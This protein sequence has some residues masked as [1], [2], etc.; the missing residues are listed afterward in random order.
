MAAIDQSFTTFDPPGSLVTN[1]TSI[2][3]AGVV[4]GWYQ[5]AS[6]THGFLLAKGAITT[7]DVTGSISG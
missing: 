3:S 2:N 7:F 5:D 1:P 4:T 6:G